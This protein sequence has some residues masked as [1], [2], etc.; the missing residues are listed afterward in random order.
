MRTINKLAFFDTPELKKIMRKV[1]FRLIPI[2][3][4]MFALAMLDRSNV[5]FVKHYI[6]VDAGIGS[7]AY[8]LGAG[9][10]FIGYALFEVPS[11]MILHRVGARF[12]LSRIMVTWGIVSICMVLVRDPYSFY[13]LRFLLGVAEA[14]FTPGA[15]LFL[16]YWFPKTFRGQAYGWFYLGVPIALMLGGPFSGWLLESSFTLGFKNWQWMFIVQG[17]LTV[18]VGIIGYFILVSRPDDA[19]WLKADEKEILN[20]ALNLDREI[21]AE[22]ELTG[23]KNVFRDW[24]VWRFVFIYFAIQMSV[25]GILFYLP[26]K[27][28]TLLK[29]QVGLE[30]G[31]YSAIPWVCT[32]V[33]LPIITRY[34]DRKAN[35]TTMAIC[36]LS[37]AVFGIVAST[38]AN[39]L[40]SFMIFVSIAIV[41]FIVV[42]PIFWNIPTQ[43]L[44][45]RAIAIGTALIGSLGNL[46]GFVA[47][48]LKNYLDGYWHNDMAGLLAL[49][50]VGL[51]GVVLLIA[52]W[53]DQHKETRTSLIQ[54]KD[55]AL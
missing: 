11:N 47:P 42:Q 49:A 32:L 41:G 8:A 24:R 50:V 4:L 38:L 20:Q 54:L 36:M 25:Y 2:I 9:I 51:I 6:E 34:A 37:C 53:F 26:T 13:A 30:V 52:L 16:T 17:V 45:G 29:M 31:Y 33:L 46:G 18:I 7:A 44:S 12:W 23:N 40:F 35:W 28:A 3:V 43:Y 15:I 14:G 55:S 22:T 1:K 48:N 19:K 10:F 39:S 5:G 27:L 21:S